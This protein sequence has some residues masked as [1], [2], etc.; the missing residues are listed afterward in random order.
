MGSAWR[1]IARRAEIRIGILI[2]S[3]DSLLLHLLAGI[4]A[5]AVHRGTGN[6]R[7]N[8]LVG[9]FER[10]DY[11]EKRRDVLEARRAHVT[12]EIRHVEQAAFVGPA[13]VRI[14]LEVS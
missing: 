12:R 8:R 4:F 3:G 14:T 5:A 10:V 11:F 6:T 9:E 13:P 7:K 2:W 1:P